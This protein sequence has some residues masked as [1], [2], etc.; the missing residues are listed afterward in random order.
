M[1]GQCLCGA[2]SFELMAKALKLYRCHCSLCRRQS[3]TASNCAAIV[4]ADRFRWLTGEARITSW[5]RPSGY[6]SD[7]CSVCGSPVPNVLRAT[8][9]YWVPAGSLDEPATLQ[10]VADIGLASRAVWDRM[11][12]EGVGQD[13]I[14]DLDEFLALLHIA[15]A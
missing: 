4:P 9:A 7:F 8:S 12:T 14:P 13:Q 11:P 5:T 1:R 2:V 15:D 6:R 3:G 10:V